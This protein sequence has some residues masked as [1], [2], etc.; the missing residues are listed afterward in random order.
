EN[1][2]PGESRT[3]DLQVCVPDNQPSE[4][5]AFSVLGVADG[6]SLGQIVLEVTVPEPTPTPVATATVTP[7]T[8]TTPAILTVV[9]AT[10]AIM[11]TDTPDLVAT[12]NEPTSDEVLPSDGRVSNNQTDM[13][14][15]IR[16]W[17]RIAF[18]TSAYPWRVLFFML[19]PFFGLIWAF[20]YEHVIDL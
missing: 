11:P 4:S 13:F 20:I 14:G 18:S 7:D 3:F 5:V 10:P 15:G 8:V 2:Q 1:V 16:E 9:T 19:L 17:F 6:V 12:S